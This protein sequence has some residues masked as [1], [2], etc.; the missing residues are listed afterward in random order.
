[1]QVSIASYARYNT[2]AQWKP[3]VKDKL[4]EFS[5]LTPEEKQDIDPSQQLE[6]GETHAHRSVRPLLDRRPA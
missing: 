6:Q 2:D 3:S 4:P 5:T 1:M